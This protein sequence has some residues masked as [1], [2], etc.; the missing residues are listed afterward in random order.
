MWVNLHFPGNVDGALPHQRKVC[1]D[2]IFWSI[3]HDHIGIVDFFQKPDFLVHKNIQDVSVSNFHESISLVVKMCK[4][5]FKW[6]ELTQFLT[7][8]DWNDASNGKLIEIMSDS[9]N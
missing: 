2:F 1:I 8:A 9:G 5:D 3:R 6:R 4:T 7:I